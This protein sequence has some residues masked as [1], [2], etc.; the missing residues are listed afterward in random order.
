M[1]N[2]KVTVTIDENAIENKVNAL[3]DES[4]MTSIQKVF[5]ETID[6]WTP[7][8]TGNLSK[9]VTVDSNGVTYNAPYS[10]RKYFTYAYHKEVHPLATSHWDKVA[11][12][13]G[14]KEVLEA[15][16]KEILVNRV[17]ELYG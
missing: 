11:M 15:K 2:V 17:N 1:L 7:F 10:R 13:Q 16:V 9:D 8:L 12:E 4:T 3:L 14:A 6:P 5:A